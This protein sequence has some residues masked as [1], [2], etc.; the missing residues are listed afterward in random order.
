MYGIRFH[1]ASDREGTKINLAVSHMGVLVFQVGGRT[2]R[3]RAGLSPAAHGLL[4]CICLWIFVVM[5]ECYVWKRNLVYHLTLPASL[6]NITASYNEEAAFLSFSHIKP[7]SLP[8]NS[9]SPLPPG[10]TTAQNICSV[11]HSDVKPE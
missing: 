11:I 10:L 7:C 5:N 8:W 6:A 3:G 2:G 1:M 4:L 9:S